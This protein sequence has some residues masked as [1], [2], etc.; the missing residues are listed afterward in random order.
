[1]TPSDKNQTNIGMIT[2]WIAHV[3]TLHCIM[4]NVHTVYIYIYIHVHVHALCDQVDS[5][6]TCGNIGL[7]SWTL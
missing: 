5:V 3:Y 7:M 2:M 4:H 6:T 1:M